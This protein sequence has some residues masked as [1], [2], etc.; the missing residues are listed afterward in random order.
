MVLFTSCYLYPLHPL[1]TLEDTF[2][3]Q[4]FHLSLGDDFSFLF[5]SHVE[6]VGNPF[7]L[8]R[9]HIPHVQLN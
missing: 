6:A 5:N 7:S 8:P 2:S 9:R 1:N 4:K 3:L